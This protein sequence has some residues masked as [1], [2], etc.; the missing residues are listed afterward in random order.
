MFKRPKLEE[1][2]AYTRN[3]IKLVPEG[4]IVD[5]LTEQLDKTYNLL[6]QVTEDQADYRYEDGKW[7]LS[8]VIGHL[9]DTERIMAYRILRIARGDQNP[10]VGFD[11]NEFVKKASFFVRPMAD[12]LEDYQNVRTAT[13]SLLK[14]LPQHSLKYRSNA[15]GFDVTVETVA[16]MVAGHERHHLKIIEEKYL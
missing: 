3:Y 10:L 11:E 1:F 7:S 2:P 6:S 9:T 5:I 8:E 4:D 12:L 14:G 13:T 16:Y 15:N